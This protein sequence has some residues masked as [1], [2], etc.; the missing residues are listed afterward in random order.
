MS[1]SERARCLHA[2]ASGAEPVPCTAQPLAAQVM[3]RNGSALALPTVQA[4]G[5]TEPQNFCSMQVL[6]ICKSCKS[7]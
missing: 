5:H 3:S 2:S 4:G 7:L 1:L 6:G